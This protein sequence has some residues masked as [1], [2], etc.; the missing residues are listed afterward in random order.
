MTKTTHETEPVEKE[1]GA[2]KPMDMVT[3]RYGPGGQREFNWIHGNCWHRHS[4]PSRV[5]KMLVEAAMK[6][7]EEVLKARPNVSPWIAFSALEAALKN[8]DLE[9]VRLVLKHLTGLTNDASRLEKNRV[10]A[11]TNGRIEIAQALKEYQVANASA[12]NS[13]MK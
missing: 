2:R 3:G 6:H 9:G 5:A 13:N 10:E 8:N 12:W 7:N 4:G 1:F 11:E